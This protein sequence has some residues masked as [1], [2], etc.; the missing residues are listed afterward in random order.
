MSNLT[1]IPFASTMSFTTA[2]LTAGTTSTYT[3]ANATEC[4]IE[5]KWATALSAQTNTA[6]PTTDSTT[7]A[8]FNALAAS[9]GCLLV[10]GITAAGAIQLAQGPIVDLDTDSN[11][12]KDG[13]APE[14]PTI[15]DTVCPIAYTVIK[16]G[17]TGSAWT[18]G[19]SNWTATGIVD[20]FVDIAVMPDRPQES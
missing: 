12:F 11:D 4:C 13:Q 1:G 14:F 7:G 15:L 9:Q 19:T 5:G 16:N 6:S 3:T 17:S 10:W 20:T 2:A 8:A 18:P